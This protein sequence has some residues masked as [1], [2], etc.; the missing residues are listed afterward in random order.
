M[1]P[2][3]RNYR[4][5]R[6]DRHGLF[7]FQF[8]LV[9]R[10]WIRPWAGIRPSVRKGQKV[11][12][13]KREPYTMIRFVNGDDWVVCGHLPHEQCPP[14]ELKRIAARRRHK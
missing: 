12:V 8:G 7:V 11:R 14:M 9:I 3:V 6:K 1:K 5:V 2:F 4:T 13:E 10:P